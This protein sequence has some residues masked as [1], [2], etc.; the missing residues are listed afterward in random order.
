MQSPQQEGRPGEKRR[1][2]ME[3]GKAEKRSGETQGWRVEIEKMSSDAHIAAA[4]KKDET[5][6]DENEQL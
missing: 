4:N 3:G 1:C 2:M 6:K 5:E